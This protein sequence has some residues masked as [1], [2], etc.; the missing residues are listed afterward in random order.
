MWLS[1]MPDCFLS[2]SSEGNVEV[3]QVNFTQDPSIYQAG[4][5]EPPKFMLR[6]SLVA[7]NWSGKFATYN[8]TEK[9]SNS[10]GLHTMLNDSTLSSIMKGFIDKIERKDK[11]DFINEKIRLLEEKLMKADN[12]THLTSER[13]IVL[14]WIAMKCTYTRN[15]N[16]LFKYFGF[17]KDQ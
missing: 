15:F 16:E 3:H 17:D 9:L 10:L 4:E 2:L 7:F 1:K 14:M 13:N 12:S 8:S 6:K 11:T 5:D